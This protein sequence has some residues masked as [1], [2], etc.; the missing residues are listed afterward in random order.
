[1]LYNRKQF[2]WQFTALITIITICFHLCV[3]HKIG[4]CVFLHLA[5]PL[6]KLYPGIKM[7]VL[8]TC[9][10]VGKE[11]LFWNFFAGSLNGETLCHRQLFFFSMLYCFPRTDEIKR[12]SSQTFKEGVMFRFV[13][14]LV[15]T[16]RFLN[17]FF[18]N[19]SMLWNTLRHSLQKSQMKKF[20][21]SLEEHWIAFKFHTKI[22]MIIII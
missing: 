13:T 16:S 11:R 4:F 9:D 8:N 22:M 15:D 14:K 5:S 19:S 6:H 21:N 20:S 1:M 7:V 10:D 12:N 18:F 2:F 17:S 3:L